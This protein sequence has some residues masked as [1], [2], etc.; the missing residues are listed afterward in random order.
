MHHIHQA[1][2]GPMSTLGRGHENT[3]HVRQF[4]G[5]LRW[6][7]ACISHEFMAVHPEHVDGNKVVVI[8]FG[9]RAML[10]HHK[11]IHTGL[12][13]GVNQRRRQVLERMEGPVDLH[14]AT[15]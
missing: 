9:V 3:T 4:S 6:N 2:R 5:F 13:D 8:H 14:H 1:V 15:A 10:L 7:D 12:V 11:D